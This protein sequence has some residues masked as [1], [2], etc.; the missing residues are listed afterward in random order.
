LFFISLSLLSQTAFLFFVLPS[1]RLLRRFCFSFPRHFSHRHLYILR[2][3]VT[4]SLRQSLFSFSVTFFIAT[5]F[6]LPSTITS[7]LRQSLFAFSPHLSHKHTFGFSFSRHVMCHI[8]VLFFLLS[9][10]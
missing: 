9:Y 4:S 2:S 7:S 8:K 1:L 3:P 10:I 6:I 5:F